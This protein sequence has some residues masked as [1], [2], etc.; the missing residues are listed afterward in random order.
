M[1]VYYNENM[2][3]SKILKFSGPT[4]LGTTFIWVYYAYNS[5]CNNSHQFFY[6]TCAIT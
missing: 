5:C 3:K 4:F 6:C 2:F 1:I